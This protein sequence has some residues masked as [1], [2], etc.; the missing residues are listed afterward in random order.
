MKTTILLYNLYFSVLMIV[1]CNH[2][3]LYSSMMENVFG[4]EIQQHRHCK[5]N[6]DS[7]DNEKPMKHHHSCTPFCSCG[8]TVFV[9]NAP[10]VQINIHNPLYSST[11]QIIQSTILT[12]TSNEYSSLMINDIWRP[13]QLS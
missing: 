2:T 11:H 3:E 6:H 1:P 13:P 9:M 5:H 10:P 4:I 12:A 7:E 8:I